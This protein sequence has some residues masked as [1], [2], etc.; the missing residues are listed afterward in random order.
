MVE[1]TAGLQGLVWGVTPDGGAILL[2]KAAIDSLWPW[3]SGLVL[4][5]VQFRGRIGLLLAEDRC[6]RSAD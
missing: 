6:S 1:E 4:E 2:L 3:C 5:N